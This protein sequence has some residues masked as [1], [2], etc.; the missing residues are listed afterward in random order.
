LAVLMGPGASSA[1]AHATIVS[2]S[3][4][5]GASETRLPGSVSLTFDEPVESSSAVLLVKAPDGSS[6]RLG[7]PRVVD[8][9][10]SA[11]VSADPGLAGQYA[12]SWRVVSADGHPVD[13]TI[14]F[15]VSSGRTASAGATVAA[16]PAS[17]A[18]QRPYVVRHG[19]L[20]GAVTLVVA[21]G[22]LLAWRDRRRTRRD[23]T[24]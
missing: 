7:P 10:V 19:V 24:G 14:D 23:P 15:E 4:G 8:N 20:I 11:V 6:V 13:G 22:V 9:T 21:V 5:S 18:S 16:D 12:V 17:T 3:P 1:F 2:T